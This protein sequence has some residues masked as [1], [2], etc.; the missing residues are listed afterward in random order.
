M[1]GYLQKLGFGVKEEKDL[2]G[3]DTSQIKAIVADDIGGWWRKTWK[4]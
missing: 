4:A 3:S 2:F 1:N